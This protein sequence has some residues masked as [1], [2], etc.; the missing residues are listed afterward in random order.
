MFWEYQKL[1]NW[2]PVFNMARAQLCN[3]IIINSY[4]LYAMYRKVIANHTVTRL[5]DY[6][7]KGCSLV[8]ADSA[9]H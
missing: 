8:Q 1:K 3:V 2:I 6:H 5:H 7:C 4:H 9:S